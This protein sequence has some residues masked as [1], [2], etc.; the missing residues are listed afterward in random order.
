MIGKEKPPVSAPKTAHPPPD[1]QVQT[2]PPVP[3]Q[4]TQSAPKY[5]QKSTPL[6]AG[7]TS[8]QSSVQKNH[9]LT[10][11]ILNL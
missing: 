8:T 4:A 6:L 9:Y 7:N 1:L 2:L 3:E 5:V 10:L 11:E